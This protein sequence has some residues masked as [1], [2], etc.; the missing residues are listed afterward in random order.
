MTLSTGQGPSG[1]GCRTNVFGQREFK[2]M[3]ALL[4]SMFEAIAVRI[5]ADRLQEP[6]LHPH[7]L[8]KI[9]DRLRETYDVAD[10]ALPARLAE[11]VERMARRERATD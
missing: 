3:R 1:A 11:L 5:S 6:T 4:P 9:G 7:S 10:E 2:S 8:Q